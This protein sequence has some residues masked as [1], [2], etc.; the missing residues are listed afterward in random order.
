MPDRCLF[1][2]GG[3]Y[4][5]GIPSHLAYARAGTWHEGLG[6][7]VVH[8]AKYSGRRNLAFEMGKA[9]ARLY[10]EEKGSTLVPVPLH[11]NSTRLFNQ[12]ECIA[13]GMAEVWEAS[14]LDGLRW[15]RPVPSQVGRKAFER[16]S[17]QKDAFSW[18]LAPVRQS[19]L[20]VDD[21]FT[22]GTTLLR[23]AETLALSGVLVKGAYSWG[24]SP[25]EALT[26]KWKEDAVLA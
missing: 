26:V 12:A 20:L 24:L 1:C 16:R 10:P 21:V 9:L 22:T 7:E 4:P 15:A 2:G 23:A 25:I 13:R 18:N 17:L 6:R 3:P 11:G 8:L 14:I 19:V 5:C